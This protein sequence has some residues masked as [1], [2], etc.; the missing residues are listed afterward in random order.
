MSR[1]RTSRIALGTLASA[2]ALLLVSGTLNGC[3]AAQAYP[4]PERPED[5]T[6]TLE[7]NPPQATI[8]F[9]LTSVNGHPFEAEENASILPGKN[10]LCLLYTSPSPRDS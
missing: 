2:A 1:P 7:I 5:Q 3:R 9:E 10:T 6:A 4:G 8:G